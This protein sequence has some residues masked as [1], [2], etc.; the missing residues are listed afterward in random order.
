MPHPL[1]ALRSMAYPG[2]VIALG[3]DPSDECDV[4]VYAV[5]GRSPSSQA[6]LLERTENA[7]VTKPT[8]PEVL[9]T[10][11]PDLLVY[12]AVCFGDRLAVSNGKQTE[13]VARASASGPVAALE[14]GLR[15]WA[16]EPDAPIFT[17]R[18]SGLLWPDGRAALSVIKRAADGSPRKHYFEF[19]LQAGQAEMIATYSGPNQN[20]LPIFRGEPFPLILAERSA[21]ATVKAFYEALGPDNANGNDFRVAAACVFVSRKDPLRRTIAILNRH[22]RKPA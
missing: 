11:N 4:V 10:G 9:K 8:D 16:Y 15:S 14:A 2:R 19:A 13:D 7:I 21:E 22:E 3:R 5:T 20:P 6:R 17:P 12:P 18:I 1:E